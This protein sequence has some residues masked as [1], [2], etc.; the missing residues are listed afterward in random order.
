MPI[1]EVALWPGRARP[2]MRVHVAEAAV[3]PRPALVIFRG[4]GYARNDGSGAGA[5][6]WAA[7]HGMV[8]VE[9]DYA[10]QATHQAHPASYA[11]AARAVR[12]VRHRAHEWSVDPERIGAMGFSAGGHL[13]SLLSTRPALWLAPEDDLASHVDARPDLVILAYPVISFVEGYTAGAFGASAERFFGR[14][15]PGEAIRR[16]FSNELHVEPTHPPVFVWTTA[17][18]EI[19]P[20]SHS[21]RFAVACRRAGVPV[22]LTIFPHGPHAMGL[23]LD[24]RGDVGTWTTRLRDWLAARWGGD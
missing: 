18:D 23:A 16:E 17:D 19:V 21:E 5:G 6:A 22:E 9:V 24:H 13:A 8:G 1:I 12:L 10:T 11:D 15:D 3:A 2:V 4:G 20:A 7:G 14:P